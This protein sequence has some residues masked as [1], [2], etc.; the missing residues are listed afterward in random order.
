MFTFQIGKWTM[1][2][3]SNSSPWW[4]QEECF[5]INQK[6][7]IAT[8]SILKECG[9][10]F[11]DSWIIQVSW[12]AQV[13]S[14]S[15]V[16]LQFNTNSIIHFL[17]FPTIKTKWKQLRDSYRTKRQQYL[18]SQPR[19]GAGGDEVV[20]KPK[21]KFYNDL[22]FLARFTKTRPMASSL[23]STNVGTSS[24]STSNNPR[25]SLNPTADSLVMIEEEDVQFGK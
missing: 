16:V 11:P 23:P 10:I 5:T 21:W 9:V 4:R 1:K 20:G 15:S 6:S 18:E 7:C 14:L 24:S 12:I 17:V 2:R 22:E 25:T 8:I 3:H 13:S 19:S